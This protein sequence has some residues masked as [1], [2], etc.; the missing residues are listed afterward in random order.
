MALKILKWLGFVLAAMILV[1][2]AYRGL[3]VDATNERVAEEIR[4][5]PDGDRAKRSMLL[6]LQDGTMYPVNY[7]LEDN[8]VF[9]GIDGLWWRE[10]RD[11]GAPVR[12]LIRGRQ[13][14][15]HGRVVLDDQAYVDNVFSRLRP[16]VPPWLPNW[17]NGK[18]V[19]ITLD[20]DDS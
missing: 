4:S 7:L 11:D 2:F 12:M 14:T 17:L 8:L 6:Y 13:Y 19:V 5:Q 15:G 10:F 9:M 16:T 20:Q 1:L 18:L 3:T